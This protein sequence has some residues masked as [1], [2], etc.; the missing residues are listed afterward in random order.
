MVRE[1]EGLVQ[2]PAFCDGSGQI[3][4]AHDYEAGVKT[5][6]PE[7][8]PPDVDLEEQLGICQSIQRGATSMAC[9]QG[10]DDKIVD[11]INHRR[12][13]EGAWGRQPELPVHEHYLDISFMVPEMVTFLKALRSTKEQRGKMSL[14][15]LY[16]CMYIYIYIYIEREREREGI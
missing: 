1:K 3:A 5:A 16:I 2:G 12:K 11:L 15:S 7:T 14:T 6:H 4:R 8:I 9:M 13:F 10:V